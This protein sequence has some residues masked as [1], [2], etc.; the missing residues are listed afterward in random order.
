VE[1]VAVLLYISSVLAH[2][3]SKVNSME[4]LLCAARKPVVNKDVRGK[5][6]VRLFEAGKEF[7]A[8]ME[9]L[10]RGWLGTKT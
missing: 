1:S 5:M 4:R 10:L 3:F 7:S 9:L 6:K 2:S 8:L